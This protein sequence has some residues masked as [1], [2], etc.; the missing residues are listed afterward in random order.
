MALSGTINGSTNNQYIQARIRWSATQDQLTNTSSVTAIF[1]VRKLSSSS[2]ATTGE[3]NW[4]LSINGTNKSIHK[5]SMNVPNNNVWQELGRN[6]V[7][8]PHNADGTKTISI[9]GSG[10]TL[11][12]TW[13]T[14]TVSGS[15]TLDAI[16]R[17]TI[18]TFNADP[19][20]FGDDLEITITPALNTFTHD[21]LYSW[22]GGNAVTIVSG[23]SSGQYDWTIPASLMN[24]I[25]NAT[26]SSALVITVKTY[27]GGSLLGTTNTAI[28]C[29]V[30][31]SVVPTI[32][33]I[34]CTDT[35]NIQLIDSTKT[36]NGWIN[37]T[38]SVT[39]SSSYRC[40]D[41]IPVVPGETINFEMLNP[42]GDQVW[43]DDT[44]FDSDKDYIGGYEDHYSTDTRI[45]E[46]FTVPANAAYVRISYSSGYSA[47][48][49]WDLFIKTLSTL[50]V[51]ATAAGAYGSTITSYLIETM[52]QVR[53]QNDID[54]GAITSSGTVSVKVTVTDSRGRSAESTT[55][56]T[57][58]D[59]EL[60]VIESALVERTNDRGIPVENGTYLRVTLGCSVSS[61]DH[62]NAMTVKIYY[63]DASDPNVQPTLARTISEPGVIAL[64][65][66]VEMISGMDVAKTYTITVEVYDILAAASTPTTISGVIQSEG[67]IISWRYGG[68]GVAFGRT[69]ETP[70]Q[71]D[72]EWEIRGR[73]GA[74]LDVPLPIT[75]GGTGANSLQGL[76]AVLLDA[77]YP[78]GCLYWSSDSTNPGTLFGGTWTA[79]TD[80]FVLAAGSTFG[81]NDTGGETEHTLTVAELPTHNHNLIHN[82]DSGGAVSGSDPTGRGPFVRE[83][84][85]SGTSTNYADFYTSDVGDGDAHNN[86]PPYVVKYC[87]ERT[88]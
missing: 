36:T 86:M 80:K 74:I 81:V 47:R 72:F 66:R 62:H 14:T 84:P 77:I 88:A 25:P 82:A 21:I 15:V 19:H 41:Y 76:I 59:Y 7:S 60:P 63:K 68:T 43:F 64:Q 9:T 55:S 39:A 3:G 28:T 42:D 1:E 30:P 38:G 27:S 10:G 70:Y 57:V 33:A 65:G 40:S 73:N 78:V 6:T 71:A 24:D 44:Y 49:W 12:T 5:T 23:F 37:N 54:V 56:I 20:Y 4:T 58:I 46:S 16:P 87:W 45:V 26:A 32:S 18:P 52:D 69:S 17:Q 83:L 31:A 61:V 22:N 34:T 11:R 67:A 13:T 51:K 29:E 2:S 53:T 35:G 50:H 48:L 79:I 8:V 75:S 85:A